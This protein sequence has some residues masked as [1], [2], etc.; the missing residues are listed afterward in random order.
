[1]RT[2]P[3]LGRYALNVY[4]E[5]LGIFYSADH[6]AVLQAV[7]ALGRLPK[8]A[9]S[10]DTDLIFALDD[11]VGGGVIKNPRSAI[12]YIVQFPRYYPLR[13]YGSVTLVRRNLS[14]CLNRHYAGQASA[15]KI[16][17]GILCIGRH[18]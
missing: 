10:L 6:P 13:R 16:N 8:S 11:G 1:M 15:I 14:G 4:G 2:V 5:S 7:A 18:H 9:Q 12:G 3:G 17:P